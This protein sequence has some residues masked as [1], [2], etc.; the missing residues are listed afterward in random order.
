MFVIFAL[1]IFIFPLSIKYEKDFTF[2]D[3]SPY[4]VIMCLIIFKFGA[5]VVKLQ[6]AVLVFKITTS[7]SPTL[8]TVL[9]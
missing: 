3:L 6:T 5:I 1:Y 4:Y 9:K 8:N 7:I 2:I